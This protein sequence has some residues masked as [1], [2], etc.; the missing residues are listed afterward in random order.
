[1]IELFRRKGFF[2]SMYIE[3][4]FAMYRNKLSICIY[5]IRRIT[6]TKL[7]STIKAE[8]NSERLAAAKV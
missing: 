8:Q 4:C 6:K 7:Q 2:M 3:K 5:I 1:M